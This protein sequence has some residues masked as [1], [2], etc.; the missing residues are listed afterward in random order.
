MVGLVGTLL[1]DSG[2]NIGS[3]HLARDEEHGEAFSLINVDSPVPAT[4]L[5]TLRKLSGVM[6][7]RQLAV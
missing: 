1:G 3:I 7:V 5:D 4:V 6:S 2:V